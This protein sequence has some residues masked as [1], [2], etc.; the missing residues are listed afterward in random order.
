[1][2]KVKTVNRDTE[3]QNPRTVTPKN[4]RIS[5]KKVWIKHNF[6]ATK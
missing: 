5:H 3:I 4:K 6:K 1:M 2:T